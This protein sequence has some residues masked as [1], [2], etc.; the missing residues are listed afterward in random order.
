MKKSS[1]LPD[2]L[3]S[4]VIVKTPLEPMEL[5]SIDQN[6]LN[7][8]HILSYYSPLIKSIKTPQKSNVNNTMKSFQDALQDRSKDY[9]N[10]NFQKSEIIQNTSIQLEKDKGKFESSA[11][12]GSKQVDQTHLTQSSSKANLDNL[13]YKKS[14]VSYSIS[15][16][17][18]NGKHEKI[19]LLN[20]V[21][22]GQSFYQNKVLIFVL[23]ISLVI[24]INRMYT[25]L[26]MGNWNHKELLLQKDTSALETINSKI[27]LDMEDKDDIYEKLNPLMGKHG[28]NL[29][30]HGQNVSKQDHQMEQNTIFL[31]K[32]IRTNLVPIFISF[33]SGCLLSIISYSLMKSRS[34]KFKIQ[35]FSLVLIMSMIPLILY[36]YLPC[37]SIII[38]DMFAL[39]SGLSLLFL[40]SKLLKCISC[41]KYYD[42]NAKYLIIFFSL[43]ICL[44]I[45]SMFISLKLALII[46]FSAI[47]P[48][49]CCYTF[50]QNTPHELPLSSLHSFY[51]K[52]SHTNEILLKNG[53]VSYLMNLSYAETVKLRLH[54]QNHKID[55]FHFIKMFSFIS[56]EVSESTIDSMSDSFN[57]K[58]PKK[59]SLNESLSSDNSVIDS[60]NSFG[61]L[62]QNVISKEVPSLSPI[63]QDFS[64][65][66]K[67]K[68]Q[69]TQL[70]R[71]QVS[72]TSPVTLRKLSNSVRS[73][74][75][76]KFGSDR[77]SKKSRLNNSQDNMSNLKLSTSKEVLNLHPQNFNPPDIEI[78]FH[79]K[80]EL[81][82]S[83]LN[84]LYKM[85][86]YLKLTKAQHKLCYILYYSNLLLIIFLS[87][88]ALV[89]SYNQLFNLSYCK[90]LLVKCVMIVFML[91]SS[92]IFSFFLSDH[93]WI[94]IRTLIYC[95]CLC[96]KIILN[97]SETSSI[98]LKNSNLV[99]SILCLGSIMSC[100]EPS[101]VSKII[102]PSFSFN[103]WFGIII[104]A[105]CI[106]GLI[107]QFVKN[108]M[109][110]FGVI[111]GACICHLIVFNL[112]RTIF[113]KKSS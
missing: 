36:S 65:P 14:K 89:L 104:V 13:L 15:E 93:I 62:G 43:G 54:I 60:F 24:G 72:N 7:P 85:F 59:L 47:L 1:S 103:L 77:Q 107:L 28:N 108:S 9:P 64:N 46:Q 99:I 19:L 69:S 11:I 81:K 95:L 30:E 25:V 63:L 34:L 26:M 106:S 21:C 51:M 98:T 109:V 73:L 49:I 35:F 86:S 87:L 91:L 33:I 84:F 17:E 40:L 102:K 22:N 74:P 45:F 96:T 42:T 27:I 16:S 88:F 5:S 32:Q 39:A 52:Q 4:S 94:S 83:K 80:S 111:L 90:E 113:N 10:P 44:S 18:K 57:V 61:N 23:L 112:S 78:V 6:Q 48:F 79:D 53:H 92:E 71:S 105:A 37:W 58:T 66:N 56:S 2:L 55:I 3:S 31:F 101:M 97:S 68:K 82:N 70:T 75:Q 76:I 29:D 50:P 67:N 38:I 8:N 20:E 12:Q 100:S 110:L 41:Q